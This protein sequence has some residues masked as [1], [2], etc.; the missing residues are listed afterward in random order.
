MPKP[1][2]KLRKT[3]ADAARRSG[4]MWGIVGDLS[5]SE[6]SGE[7]IGMMERQRKV[8]VELEEDGEAMEDGEFERRHGDRREGNVPE[9]SNAAIHIEVE[10]VECRHS[11]LLRISIHYRNC[12][13]SNAIDLV[14]DATQ[15]F[16]NSPMLWKKKI[17]KNHFIPI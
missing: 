9:G 13:T 11:Q 4:G 2:L 1:I 17:K 5:P 15:A 10:A 12:L 7:C 6:A 16:T 3:T 8:V 14:R